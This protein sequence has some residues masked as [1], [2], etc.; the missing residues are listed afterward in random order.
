MIHEYLK[1]GKVRLYLLLS[2]DDTVKSVSTEDEDE[3]RIAACSWSRDPGFVVKVDPELQCLTEVE[4]ASWRDAQKWLAKKRL[5]LKRVICEQWNYCARRADY[6]DDYERLVEDVASQLAPVVGEKLA[7][8]V[9]VLL[10]KE[11]LY[12]LCECGD[13]N[14]LMNEAKAAFKARR[15]TDDTLR[16]FAHITDLDPDNHYAHW[17]QGV[18][19]DSDQRYDESLPHYERAVAISPSQPQYLNNLGYAYTNLGKDLGT[20]QEYISLAL[21]MAWDDPYG[22]PVCLDS[23]GWLLCQRGDV[24]QGL[25]HLLA[26]CQ[27]VRP[28]RE[29]FGTDLLQEI[30]YH[31]AAGYKAV[32]RCAECQ[33]I[34]EEITQLDESSLWAEKAKKL[35]P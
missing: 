7:D 24:E 31:L 28:K 16:L 15:F 4:R 33:G 3:T 26:A 12:S 34:V 6:G 18:I 20:A 22:R 9:A 35:R 19:Y 23:L 32:H 11:S 21:D 2:Q 25:R 17:C 5:E 8:I 14:R 30:L 29:E 10:F 27:I 1:L 13:L